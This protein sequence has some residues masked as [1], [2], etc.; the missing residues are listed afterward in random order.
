VP[1]STADTKL[2]TGYSNPTLSAVVA[3]PARRIDGY[4]RERPRWGVEALTPAERRV[5]QLAADGLSNPQIAATTKVTRGTIESQLQAVYRKL[6]IDRR[7]ELPDALE[8]D[9]AV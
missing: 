1:L 9:I 2:M 4:R 7:Q 8:P 6:G 5:A 3:R